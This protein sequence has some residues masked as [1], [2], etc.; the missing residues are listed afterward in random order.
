MI[1][2]VDVTTESGDDVVVLRT[3]G[4]IVGTATLAGPESGPPDHFNRVEEDDVLATGKLRRT[5][6]AAV[7]LRRLHTVKEARVEQGGIEWNGEA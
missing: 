4:R 5:S 1:A 7:D 2:T 3:G 6:R